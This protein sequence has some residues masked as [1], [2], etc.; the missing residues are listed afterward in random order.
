MLFW[1]DTL[2][3]DYQWNR[4]MGRPVHVLQKKIDNLLVEADNFY[5]F[6]VHI[7]CN[8]RHLQFNRYKNKIVV[9]QFS[10][11]SLKLLRHFLIDGFVGSVC[12]AQKKSHCDGSIV[13]FDGCWIKNIFYTK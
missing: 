7:L 4:A 10:K 9:A 13:I 11:Y 2:I 1:N 5:H 12:V 6:R 8:T 3:E